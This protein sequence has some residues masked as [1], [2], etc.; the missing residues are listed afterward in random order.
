MERAQLF[1]AVTFA[2]ILGPVAI[3]AIGLD[4]PFSFTV[5]LVLLAWLFMK[6]G[7]LKALSNRAV[8]LETFVGAGIVAADL[9]E[10]FL[11][12]SSIGLVDMLVIFVGVS[13]ALYGI[14]SMRFFAVPAAY[15]AILI[16][17][18]WLEYNIP[19]VQT[20][21]YSL[22]TMM[23]ALMRILG[24]N[25]SVAGNVVT[26]QGAQTLLLQVDGPCTG[27][28]GILAFG[29][30]GSMAVLDVKSKASR[31]IPILAIGFLGAF[32][33]NIVRL[34]GVFLAFEYLGPDLGT[35]THVYL[36]YALFIAW[37]L[38]FWSAAFRYLAPRRA[39][40]IRP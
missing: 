8:P 15:V 3:P 4:Y 13:I 12:H 16:G 11:A 26:L 24:V 28:K 30:L 2:A 34:F 1:V 32:A 38:I 40:A 21:Q 18:Y 7:A 25:A 35:V 10:N 33:I 37:V 14:K 39:V 27:I 19:E 9:V 20:L 6:W 22:A 23:A 5:S 31:I 17:G 36:G 29:M